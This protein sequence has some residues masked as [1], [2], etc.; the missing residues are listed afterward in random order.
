ML[1]WWKETDV[2]NDLMQAYGHLSV[3]ERLPAAHADILSLID[4]G[5]LVALPEVSGPRY[6]AVVWCTDE[7]LETA[8]DLETVEALMRE[9]ERQYKASWE[10]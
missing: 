8:L 4:A 1:L 10:N 6:K 7:E 9:T 5:I 2:Q 3:D